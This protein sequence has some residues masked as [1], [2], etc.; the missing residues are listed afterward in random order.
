MAKHSA[1]EYFS[2]DGQGTVL[3]IKQKVLHALSQV[4]ER[5]S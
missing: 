4:A 3:E 1:L 5:Q 2:V